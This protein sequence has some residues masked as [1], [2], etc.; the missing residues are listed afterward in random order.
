[1]SGLPKNWMGFPIKCAECGKEVPYNRAW[2]DT[3]GTG[4]YVCGKECND[5]LKKR[6]Y[7]EIVRK[8]EEPC[9]WSK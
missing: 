4:C 5:S 8:P 3:F 2:R 7:H 6:Y 1:M 9:E